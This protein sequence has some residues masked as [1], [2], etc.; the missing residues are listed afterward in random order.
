LTLVHST[1]A[2]SLLQDLTFKIA[3]LATQASTFL[4][5]IHGRDVIDD[6]VYLT[7]PGTEMD[8][9]DS[10]IIRG[11]LIKALTRGISRM[12]YLRLT[13]SCTVEMEHVER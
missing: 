10:F 3:T 5:T 12:T 9:K 7:I 8:D 11:T 6:L 13:S 1:V 2:N 4:S